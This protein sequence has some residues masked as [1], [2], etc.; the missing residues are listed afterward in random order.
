M[1]ENGAKES[2]SLAAANGVL[3]LDKPLGITSNIAV[4]RVRRLFDRAKAGHTGTLDPLATGLLPICIGEATKFSHPILNSDKSYRAT[5]RLGWRSTTGDSEGELT[6]V[7]EPVFSDEELAAALRQ[8]TGEIEQLPPMYSAVRVGGERLYKLARK[9]ISVERKPRCIRIQRLEVL[10][11]KGPDL[12]ISVSCSKGT[13]IRV[14]AEDLAE[15]LGTAAYLVALRR[16]SIGALEVADAIDMDS[17]EDLPEAHRPALLKPVDL[18]LNDLPKLLLSEEDARRLSH[19]QLIVGASDNPVPEIRVYTT[20][21]R[22]LGLGEVQSD[23]SLK[24]KRLL[25]QAF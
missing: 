1:G 25:S 21:G 13:Y 17:L 20:D 18:L 3:L 23:R 8:L 14:L 11:R 10:D 5:M 6:A 2:A 19:G 4:Q 22:F 9:G 16:E 15:K 24:A 12:E 7:G